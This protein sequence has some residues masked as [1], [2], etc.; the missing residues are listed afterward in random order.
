M[1]ILLSPAKRLADGSAPEGVQPSE[2]TL[3]TAARTVAR[4]AKRLDAGDLERLMGIS[5]TLASLNAARFRAWGRG[6]ART[7]AAFTFAG[8]VYLGLDAATLATPALDYAQRHV[9]ILSGL[10]GWLRPFDAIEPYRLEMG[11]R[12]AVGA[13]PSLVDYWRPKLARAVRAELAGHEDPTLFNLASREY[14]EPL[15]GARL[16]GRVVEAVFL[17]RV[18]GEERPNGFAAKRARGTLARWCCEQGAMNAE[19]A[20]DFDRDGYRF[21]ARGSNAVRMRFIRKR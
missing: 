6:Q 15:A 1:L 9:R 5:P 20:R 11:T 19:A 13:A 17:D 12:L 3:G 10:Y 8:D 16:P 18:A 21:D 4:T 2:P 14:F 7:P